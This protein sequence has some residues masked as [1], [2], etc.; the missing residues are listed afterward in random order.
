M[1]QQWTFQLTSAVQQNWRRWGARP[2]CSSR[3]FCLVDAASWLDGWLP[4]KHARALLWLSF[5]HSLLRRL[6]SSTVKTKHASTLV[7]C[8]ACKASAARLGQ[9]KPG[10]EHKLTLVE[11]DDKNHAS[12][13]DAGCGSGSQLSMVGSL[14]LRT[15]ERTA[16]RVPTLTRSQTRCAGS[17]GPSEIVG[18]G[19]LPKMPARRVHSGLPLMIF[20]ALFRAVQM[21]A[22][23]LTCTEASGSL[24]TSRIAGVQLGLAEN[25]TGVQS[26]SLPSVG[27]TCAVSQCL[28]LFARSF[29][30]AGCRPE[31]QSCNFILRCTA[32]SV[33][34]LVCVRR[35]LAL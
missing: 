27:P 16:F 20:S 19:R 6:L 25:E 11:V 33:L 23:F 9:M 2:A 3:W 21:S 14:G 29:Q 10:L 35:L 18:R 13:A 34:G 24:L 30:F 8:Q 1:E 5:R 7:P 12:E 28:C 4:S 22:L 17:Q 31:R 26:R 15:Y 32:L